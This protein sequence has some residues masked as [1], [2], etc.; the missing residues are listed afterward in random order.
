MI[1]RGKRATWVA[2]DR[3]G[4]ERARFDASANMGVAWRVFQERFRTIADEPG[5]EIRA[6]DHREAVVRSDALLEAAHA[7]APKTR[8]DQIA[9]E[10]TLGAGSRATLFRPHAA[11]RAEKVVPVTISRIMDDGAFFMRE[12]RGY[13][14]PHKPGGPFEP[15]A[16]RLIPRVAGRTR[17]ESAEAARA[18]E[19][20]LVAAQEARADRERAQ[21]DAAFRRDV[22]RRAAGPRLDVDSLIEGRGGDIGPELAEEARRRASTIDVNPGGSMRH[23]RRN[24]RSHEPYGLT[25]RSLE[26]QVRILKTLKRSDLIRWLEWND[27]NGVWSDEGFRREF[28][29][30]PPPTEHYRGVIL[31]MLQDDDQ[32]EQ[33]AATWNRRYFTNP[34][35]RRAHAN[36]GK[37]ALDTWWAA[38]PSD[39]VF[40]CSGGCGAKGNKKQLSVQHPE[41]VGGRVDVAFCPPCANAENERRRGEARDHREKTGARCICCGKLATYEAG[42]IED[43][44]ADL[45]GRCMKAAQRGQQRGL[46][47]MPGGMGL[48]MGGGS[49]RNKATLIA[50]AK[51]GGA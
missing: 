17:A 10:Q 48:F 41:W 37:K 9:F 28:D 22:E 26:D 51:A 42:T 49:P 14:Y 38:I 36:V 4:T 16:S 3:G 43:G 1:G 34:G 35:P 15:A 40:M 13:V 25:E 19:R 39:K 18:K 45:C 5:V 32:P 23:Y 12:L 33:N 11:K 21:A 31:A 2:F 47:A 44:K 24:P 30:D 20:G 6:Y 27:P 46:A 50:W 29:D 7:A 8:E